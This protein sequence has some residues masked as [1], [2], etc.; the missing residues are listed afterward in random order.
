MEALMRAFE[1]DAKKPAPG[2]GAGFNKSN[3][4]CEQPFLE[5]SGSAVKYFP[6]NVSDYDALRSAWLARRFRCSPALAH[7]LAELCF[8]RR[9]GR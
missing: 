6:A 4:K 5:K 7:V 3:G 1:P 9:A 2:R 8:A